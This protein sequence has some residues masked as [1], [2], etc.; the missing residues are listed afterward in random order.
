M[1]QVGYL[2]WELYIASNPQ[3]IIDGFVKLSAS[4]VFDHENGVTELRH[5][6]VLEDT[7]NL[8]DMRQV[9]TWRQHALKGLYYMSFPLS[10]VC[11]WK[12]L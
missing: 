2:I 12:N 7:D 9:M 3:Y 4:R 6:E 5:D 8:S 11:P 1:E 10:V